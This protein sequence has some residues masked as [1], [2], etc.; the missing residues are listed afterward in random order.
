M[1]EVEVEVGIAIIE[2]DRLICFLRWQE[3]NLPIQ[4]I[5]GRR[6]LGIRKATPRDNGGPNIAE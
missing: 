1:V 6:R 4:W 2:V 5:R 3:R